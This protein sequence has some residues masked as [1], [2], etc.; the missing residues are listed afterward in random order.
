VIKTGSRAAELSDVATFPAAIG[1]TTTR[2]NE[3]GSSFSPVKFV[4]FDQAIEW[5]MKSGFFAQS[6][7]AIGLDRLRPFAKLP[8]IFPIHDEYIGVALLAR[9]I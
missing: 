8:G 6:I 1:S 9:A 4:G 7:S 5:G 3:A 2:R